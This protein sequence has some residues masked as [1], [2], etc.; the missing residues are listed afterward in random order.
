MHVQID[1]KSHD[2]NWTV[3]L[4]SKCWERPPFWEIYLRSVC[5]EQIPYVV[6]N[7]CKIKNSLTGI[8]F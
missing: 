8:I 1:L 7:L 6:P 4:M 3:Q 2:E 5:F